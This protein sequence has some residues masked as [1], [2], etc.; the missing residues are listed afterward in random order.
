LFYYHCDQIGT[1]L[2]MTDDAS[3]VVWEASY[4]AWGE[5]QKVIERASQA[6]GMTPRNP[7]RFQ[8]QQLDEESGL[9]YNRHRY[10]DP[11]MG[12]FISMDPIGLTGGLNLYQ[13]APNPA[14]WVDPL[15][16][17]CC[18]CEG[19]AIIRHYAVQGSRT[20]HYTVEV[21]SNT[22]SAH[23]HQTEDPETGDTTIVNERQRRVMTGDP[24]L[25]TAEVPVP[26]PNSAIAYQQSKIGANLGKYDERTNSCVDHVANVLR[27]GGVDVPQGPLGQMKFLKRLGFKVKVP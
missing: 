4:K 24:I 17:T 8:G 9:H 10:Y 20:G 26:A 11:A 14:Q 6:A 27:A 15:G 25:H 1:P 18:P 7:I 19:K 21:E 13:Y 3:E 23:T 5:T 16:L 22:A 12:R 2:L